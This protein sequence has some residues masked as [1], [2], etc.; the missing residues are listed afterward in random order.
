MSDKILEMVESYL[1]EKGT[2]YIRLKNMGERKSAPM[3]GGNVKDVIV[4]TYDLNI[5]SDN[6][7]TH[8][9]FIDPKTEKMLYIMTNHGYIEIE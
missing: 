4:V 3:R 6:I 8:F 2:K 9:V 5:E 1:K 7:L